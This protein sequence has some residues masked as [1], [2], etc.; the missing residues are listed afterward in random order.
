MRSIILLLSCLASAV[1]QSVSPQI[2]ISNNPEVTD[3]GASFVIDH[4]QNIH[5]IWTGYYFQAGAPDNTVSDLYYTNNKDGQFAKPIKIA[6]NHTNPDDP[7]YQ[8]KYYSTFVLSTVDQENKAHFIF[9]R[10]AMQN[11]AWGSDLYYGHIKDDGIAEVYPLLFNGYN[12]YL[13]EAFDPVQPRIFVDSNNNV[14]VFFLN[15]SFSNA[16]YHLKKIGPERTA[17]TLSVAVED[18]M[19]AWGYSAV[20]DKN[21]GVHIVYNADR[22]LP[23]QHSATFYVNNKSGVFSTL[24]RVTPGNI[25]SMGAGM[26]TDDNGFVHI[27]YDI[28]GTVPFGMTHHQAGY[29]NNVSGSFAPVVDL[30][31]FIGA[32]LF[33]TGAE[34]QMFYT[35]TGDK[36]YHD[37][38]RNGVVHTKAIGPYRQWGL[39]R[40][41]E[42]ELL[43]Y[44]SIWLG[45][46][47][48]SEADLYYFTMNYNSTKVNPAVAGVDA[49]VDVQLMQNYPNPFNAG[50]TIRYSLPRTGLV[51]LKV[52]DLLGHEIVVLVDKVQVAGQYSVTF[53]G[54]GLQSGTYFVKIETADFTDTK[55]LTLLK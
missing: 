16:I 12:I 14:H 54:A 48:L 24:V 44:N 21:D 41:N 9:T 36:W 4:N 23:E 29:V 33:F 46:E 32:P 3:Y 28:F 7:M 20:F 18:T 40:K 8:Q 11:D 27:V 37:S 52:Y 55:K 51:T 17:W 31:H 34:L 42:Q 30:D 50:T 2:N 26:I 1:A 43:F 25:H 38:F 13:N 10:N 49:I 5:A 6:A 45:T 47:L 39:V 15:M 35:K 19:S 53:D 22:S